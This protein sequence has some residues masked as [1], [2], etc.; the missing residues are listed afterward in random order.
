MAFN[1][2]PRNKC[3]NKEGDKH[4]YRPPKI[5]FS[6]IFHSSQ[7]LPPAGERGRCPSGRRLLLCQSCKPRTPRRLSQSC[8]GF[9]SCGIGCP[10]PYRG[11]GQ[12]FRSVPFSSRGPWNDRRSSEQAEYPPV[13]GFGLISQESPRPC[14]QW[15][16]TENTS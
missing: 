16:R 13:R 10:R 9:A 1:E 6:A 5:G 3:T 12:S 11:C 4:A 14:H 15:N 7:R 8:S 2:Q